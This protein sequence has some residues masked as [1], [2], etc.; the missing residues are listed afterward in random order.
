MTKQRLW[1]KKVFPIKFLRQ[2]LTTHSPSK[3][4]E[5]LGVDHNTMLKF[6]KN[7]YKLNLMD[8]GYYIKLSYE[9]KQSS[10]KNKLNKIYNERTQLLLE[11]GERNPFN[12]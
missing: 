11:I 9:R 7:V 2:I 3:I 1:L 5:L 10:V 6:M 4:A 8:K 12:Q